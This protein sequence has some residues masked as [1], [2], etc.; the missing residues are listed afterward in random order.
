MASTAFAL[1][2][3]IATLLDDVAV[4]SKAAAKQTSGVV[5]D[6]MALNAEQVM[7]FAA[8]RELPVVWAVAKGPLINKAILVPIAMLLSAFASWIIVPLLMI[9][10]SY[11]CFEGSEKLLHKA[12]EKE[13][14]VPDKNVD[15]AAFEKDR[16]RGAIKTDFILSAEIIA[17][18]LGSIAEKTLVQQAMVLTIVA[19]LM[20]VFVYGMVGFIVKIDDAGLL[21]MR[22]PSQAMKK[23][24]AG[25]VWVAPLLMHLL[26][27]AGMCAMFMVGG[28]IVVH[29][30]PFLHHAVADAAGAVGQMMG[31]AW[32]TSGSN[33]LFEAI[34][35][36]VWGFVLIGLMIPV[37]KAIAWFRSSS[38]QKA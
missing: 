1:F 27:K 37:S 2:D 7:G 11:L 20:T 28:G 25:L 30:L 31:G 21:L 22:R 26:A 13:T 36:I 34:I 6:D 19:T 24:G 10:G 29:G 4:L 9:G 16:I 32:A 14:D 17:I 12:D 3:D 15:L 8:S 18:I 23:I 33:L 5:A 35:G 38:E